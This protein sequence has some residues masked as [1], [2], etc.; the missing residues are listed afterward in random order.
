[1]QDV[2]ERCG[3]FAASV[4]RVPSSLRPLLRAQLAAVL[5]AAVAAP[6]DELTRWARR[7][8]G[9]HPL[10][11]FAEGV[12]R[13]ESIVA[14]VA[15]ADGAEWG[16]LGRAGAPA[17]VTALSLGAAADQTFEEL[18]RAQLVAVELGLR[19][20]LATVLG[21]HLGSD[22]PAVSAVAGAIAAAR[23]LRLDAAQTSRALARALAQPQLAVFR[24]AD[25]VSAASATL[26]GVIAAELAFEGGPL[27]SLRADRLSFAPGVFARLGEVWLTSTVQLGTPMQAVHDAA[28]EVF[29]QSRAVRRAPLHPDDVR[30]LEIETTILRGRIELGVPEERV[31]TR[32][33]WELTSALLFRVAESVDPRHFFR[34]TSARE[35]AIALYRVAAGL[36]LEV[37]PLT[38]VLGDV[39]RL[40]S[41]RSRGFEPR[42]IVP[43]AR[44]HLTTRDGH[45]FSADR[46]DPTPPGGD[47]LLSLA[48]AR[49]LAAAGPRRGQQIF[50]AIRAPRAHM[51]IREL[52]AMLG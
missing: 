41:L 45:R 31:E 29:A 48:R 32:H 1:M 40:L 42:A 20:G 49:L 9:P 6:E 47:R 23:I 38:Q 21:P 16:L 51:R 13:M 18:E 15:R 7:S 25:R 46:S 4:D 12:A 10:L 37:P 33:A 52:V 36:G 26:D 8:K 50:D 14:G 44:V 30:R 28:H 2:L 39:T 24:V 11:P 5:A 43:G 34:D 35:L 19:F 3:A 22:T 27:P 17:I